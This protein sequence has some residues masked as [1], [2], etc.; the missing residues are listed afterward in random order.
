MKQ[1]SANKGRKLNDRSKSPRNERSPRSLSSKKKKSTE[2]SNEERAKK[3]RSLLRTPLPPVREKPPEERSRVGT[4][5]RKIV[6]S[7]ADKLE[8]PKIILDKQSDSQRKTLI[9]K[10]QEQ[11]A[12][13]S[14][15]EIL[16]AEA[17]IEKQGPHQGADTDGRRRVQLDADFV[18]SSKREEQAQIG[19]TIEQEL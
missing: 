10:L 11:T 2:M 3:D 7:E 4:I 5:R 18:L 12:A 6:P 8:L 1:R 14:A 13:S 19:Q 17:E 16:A 9:Q 15:Q